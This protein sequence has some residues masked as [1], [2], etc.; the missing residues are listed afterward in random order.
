MDEEKKAAAEKRAAEK[1]ALYVSPND[2][3][4]V[5][6]L[7]EYVVETAGGTK[8]AEAI[9]RRPKV[10]DL[11][12]ADKG[13]GEAEKAVLLLASLTSIP[14]AVFHDMDVEDFGRISDV[15]GDLTEGKP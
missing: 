2:D 9:V 13:A 4:S 12:V 10:K 6:V 11:L 8:Y 14:V 3:G 5:T 1:K 7:F 15:I